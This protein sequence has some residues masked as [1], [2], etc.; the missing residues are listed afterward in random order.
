MQRQKRKHTLTHLLYNQTETQT[1]PH[2]REVVMGDPS[3]ETLMNYNSID[4]VNADE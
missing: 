3:K 2:L 1:L 4:T